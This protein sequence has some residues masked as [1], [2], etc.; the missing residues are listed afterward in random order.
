MNKTLEKHFTASAII[1]VDNRILLVWHEI[2]KVWLYPGGHREN[3]ESL[4]E[5]VVREVWEETGLLAEIIGEK[6]ENISDPVADVSVLH[7]PY[8]TLCELS[9]DHYNVDL[10]YRCRIKDDFMAEN[11]VWNTE[12]MGF[13][14]LDDLEKMELLPNFRKLV[15]KVFS[16]S[17]QDQFAQRDA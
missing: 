5:T 13:F 3:N 2:L 9:G 6:D 10:V 7:N 8:I 15:K 11:A 1:I 14:S 16:E 12:K 17:L 4:D